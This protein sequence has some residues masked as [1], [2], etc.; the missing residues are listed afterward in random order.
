MQ[1]E[2]AASFF[3][4]RTFDIFASFCTCFDMADNN[5]GSNKRRREES[6]AKGGGRDKRR[7]KRNNTYR[8][9]SS[10][11]HGVLHSAKQHSDRRIGPRSEFANT[12]S[13]L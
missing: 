13:E 9:G 5:N 7:G 11:D 8:C 1:I 3:N 4:E 12:L 6:P 2:H 10:F